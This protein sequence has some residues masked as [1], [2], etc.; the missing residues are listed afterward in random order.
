MLKFFRKYLQIICLGQ[1]LE[2]KLTVF[3]G[4][5]PVHLLLHNCPEFCLL[6]G[7]KLCSG[8]D[9][10]KMRKNRSSKLF[11][12]SVCTLKVCLNNLLKHCDPLL[13]CSIHC[14][15]ESMVL[16]LLSSCVK[17]FRM[18]NFLA[19]LMHKGPNLGDVYYIFIPSPENCLIG[20]QYG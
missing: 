7:E 16:H 14:Y 19:V 12:K 20:N 1:S 4:K 13:F 6:N 18:A 5:T 17:C 3:N 8:K 2:Q 15:F 9:G 10:I 11:S